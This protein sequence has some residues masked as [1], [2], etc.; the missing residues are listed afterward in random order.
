LIGDAALPKDK[1]V[2]FSP[3]SPYKPDSPLLDSGLL[4]PVMLRQSVIVESK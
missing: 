3:F 4:G 2:T 1:R